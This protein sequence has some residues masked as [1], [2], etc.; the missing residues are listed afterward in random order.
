MTRIIPGTGWLLL[1]ALL[2]SSPVTARTSDDCQRP[3]SPGRFSVYDIDGDGY[4]SREE[5][6]L[7][8]NEFEQRHR[9][10]GRPAHRMLRILRFE[11]IDSN[12]DGRI[13]VDEMT[14]ALRKR[15]KGPGWRWRQST[16]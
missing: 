14:S 6:E 15:R 1:T 13:C 12:A 11:E 16:N 7:F 3:A 5:F 9:N 10:S 8:Y 4:L 2:L